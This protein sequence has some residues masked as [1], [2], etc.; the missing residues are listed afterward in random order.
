MGVGAL[1]PGV[2]KSS[3]AMI[4]AIWSGGLLVLPR[5]EYQQHGTFSVK[6]WYEI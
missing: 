6:E 3:E 5:G 1:V 2:A 4:M